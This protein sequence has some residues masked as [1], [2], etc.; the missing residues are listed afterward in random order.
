MNAD[1][2]RCDSLSE[3]IIDTIRNNGPITFHDFMDMCLYYPELGYYTSGRQKIGINGD[4]YTS[5]DFTSLLGITIGRQME[6]MWLK[7]DRPRFTIVEYG[8]G[9]GSLCAD[10]MKHLQKNE[11][12]YKDLNYFI[13]EKKVPTTK[14]NHLNEKVSWYESINE[15]Q[16]FTGCVISN[17]VV[18]NFPVHVVQMENELMES[19]VMYDHDNFIEFL[20]PAGD[21]LKNYFDEL[22][23]KLPKGYRTEIN[24][25]AIAWMHDLSQKIKKGFVLTIDYGFS[26]SF[27]YDES[28]KDGTLLCYHHHKIYSDPFRKIGEQDITSHVNFTALVHWG[29]K[30]GLCPCG[31]TSQAHFM[32][33]LGLV[34]YIRK[35]GQEKNTGSFPLLFSFLNDMGS[36]L[37][38]LIQSKNMKNKM[39]SGLMIS[40]PLD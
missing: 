34:E 40:E 13:I 28:R 33:A 39:L 24:L 8:G 4:Y 22:H 5:P 38:V 20:K 9:N 31:F 37:K 1:L 35:C 15:I 6:E 3:I 10:I 26:N 21:E 23:V 11:S 2:V 25:N 7:I 19:Y 27:L 32:H 29:Q 17:E 14:L 16:A 18:D 12:M 36:K 30:S